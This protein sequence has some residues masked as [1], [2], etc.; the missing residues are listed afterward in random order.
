MTDTA[1]TNSPAK[2]AAISAAAVLYAE[3]CKSVGGKA[4]NGD[5]LPT[6][7][8]F[9]ADEAK[10]KQVEAWIAVG[11]IAALTPD[12]LVPISA[13]SDTIPVPPAP[14]P[15]EVA[16]TKRFRRELDDILSQI[17]AA[18][19]SEDE[20][21]ARCSEERC[22][23]MERLKECIMWLGMDLKAMRE[24]GITAGTGNPYPSSYDPNSGTIEPTADG[25]SLGS[26][27]AE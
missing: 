19:T 13:K 2:L 15:P 27:V 7:D 20:E 3:Y 16:D 12:R 26:D 23:A 9:F 4:F 14:V 11:A 10:S 25:L 6:W 21:G 17:A 22:I 8:E 5:P 18:A 1:S 24:E